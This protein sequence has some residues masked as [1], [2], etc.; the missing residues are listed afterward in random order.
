MRMIF[1]FFAFFSMSLFVLS[2][3]YVEE[4]KK[5][6]KTERNFLEDSLSIH[7]YMWAGRILYVRNK[8]SKIFDTSPKKWRNNITNPEWNDGDSFVTNYIYHPYFG[9]LYYQIYKDLGYE[10]NQAYIGSVLQST[11]W[12]FIIEGTV[13]KPSLL[14]TVVT[15]VFG[16]P[17]GIYFEK[18]T[19]ELEESPYLFK[20]A[21]SYII[22][23]AK[24]FLS[25]GDMGFVNPVSGSF[26]VYKSFEYSTHEQ[27]AEINYSFLGGTPLPN[28][29]F[30]LRSYFFDI[31]QYRGGG[32]DILYFVDTEFANSSNDFGLSLS[33][34]W[35][36]SY[37]GNDKNYEVVDN[38]FE[39]GNFQ[40]GIKK[41]FHASPSVDVSSTLDLSLPTS[42]VWDDSKNRLEKLHPNSVFLKDTLHDS[43]I[44]APE[45]F[46]ISKYVQLGFGTELFFNADDYSGE[47]E[48]VFFVYD[49]D[50]N[51]FTSKNNDY[52][53]LY[54]F[55]AI[56]QF[57]ERNKNLD[58]ISA[59]TFRLRKELQFGISFLFPMSG[60]IQK[61]MHNGIA[62]D[63]AF[64]FY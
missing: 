63:L 56:D 40:V 20:R 9:A 25:E 28:N 52:V 45:V 41:V 26:M 30:R 3:D 44:V 31:K 57:T 39:V 59:V 27:E 32:S 21:L 55:R 60:E 38:G 33:F 34:P 7:Y 48:E 51:L 15:P 4:K 10:N 29:L 2:E 16:I 14:D 11:L 64:P 43:T 49:L 6:S 62:V 58:A 36:G 22:N 1:I 47:R 12:E 23:P 61:Y 13:E 18:L 42:T 35:A 37:D 5:Q 53:L 24:I 46:L 19:T 17:L 50:I 8:D 54:E